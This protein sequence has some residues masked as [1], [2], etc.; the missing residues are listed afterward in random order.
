L[1]H[2]RRF[3]FRRPGG[4]GAWRKDLEA[5]ALSPASIRRKLSAL[6]SLFNYLCERTRFRQPCGRRE[7]A[8]RQQQRSQEPQ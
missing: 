6:S 8:G 4:S 1:H 3:G 2:F 7:T 5:R